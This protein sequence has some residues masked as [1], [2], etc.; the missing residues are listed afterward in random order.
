MNQELKTINSPFKFLDAYTKQDKDS[1]FGRDREIEDLYQKVFESR[2]LLVYG[3]SGTGKTS[4]I[5]CGLGNKFEDTDWLPINIRRGKNINDSL[6]DEMSKA[7][8]TEVKQGNPIVKRIK[9]IYLDYFRPIYL[10]FDQFEELFIFGDEK[11]Q[12]EFLHIINEI[13]ESNVECRLIFSIREEYLANVSDFEYII[14]EFLSNKLRI[15]KMTA[16]H[17]KEVIED[18]CR[19][20]GIEVEEGFADQL[21][22]KLNPTGKQIELTYLQVY[23]D[24]IYRISS[25][26][27]AFSLEHIK[28]VGDVTDILGSFLDEQ[29]NELEDP[30]IG[31]FVLKGF[32]SMQGTRKKNSDVDILQ[33]VQMFG[34]K[35]KI[36]S[37]KEIL[38]Q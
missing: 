25:D 38:Q 26:S 35:V 18:S 9:S 6:Y 7:A 3:L 2:I 21:L 5:N 10:I 12:K 22:E 23:L 30:E 13:V 28:K 27:N 17:A 8:L 16:Y 20:H 29:I 33:F 32:V 37:L 24:K 19:I 15:G 1:F 31:L 11:E 34:K 36:E 14:P 4:I